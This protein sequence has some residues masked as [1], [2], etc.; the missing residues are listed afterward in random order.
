MQ[1][2]YAGVKRYFVSQHNEKFVIDIWE[3][4]II[5]DVFLTCTFNP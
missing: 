5:S 3:F 4:N 1:C 2:I